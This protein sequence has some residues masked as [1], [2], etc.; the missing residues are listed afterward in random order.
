MFS[1]LRKELQISLSFIFIDF[2][3]VNENME[4]YSFEGLEDDYLRNIYEAMNQRCLQ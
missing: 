4:I 2:H 3:S 1:P